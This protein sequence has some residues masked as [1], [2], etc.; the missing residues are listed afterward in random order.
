MAQAFHPSPPLANSCEHNFSYSFQWM[1]LKSSRVVT[2]G[3][4]CVKAG[5]IFLSFPNRVI[6]LFQILAY[7][8]IANSCEHN[9]SYSFK[10][11][12]LK[13]SRIVTHGMQLC[14]KAGSFY[15]FFL[16]EFRSFLTELCPVFQIFAYEYSCFL[17]WG[18]TNSLGV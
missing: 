4:L 8:Y 13:P 9:T 10:W 14:L 6:P 17:Y 7:A 5:F 3:K 11:M 1:I 18:T 12:I 16:T 15:S 2:H